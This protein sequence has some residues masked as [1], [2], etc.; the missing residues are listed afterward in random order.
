MGPAGAVRKGD[1]KL[2]QRYER[3]DTPELYHLRDDMGE[4]RNLASQ[5]PEMVAELTAMLESWRRNA[6]PAAMKR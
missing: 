1:Y 4:R 5:Y 6:A 3:P 2:I